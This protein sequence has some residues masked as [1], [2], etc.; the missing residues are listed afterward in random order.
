MHAVRL[1]IIMPCTAQPLEWLLSGST[2]AL[3]VV[4]VVVI[5]IYLGW[6][7]VGERLLSAAVPYEVRACVRACCADGGR[8]GA[9]T[10]QGCDTTA[11]RQPGRAQYGFGATARGGP[12]ACCQPCGSGPTVNVRLCVNAHPGRAGDGL[13]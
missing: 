12:A 6:A 7:Y 9:W 2:G 5:R 4:A 11:C 3:L 8:R 1:H 10:V 13:V